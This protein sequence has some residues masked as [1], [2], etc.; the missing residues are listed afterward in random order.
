MVMLLL[1]AEPDSREYCHQG[2]KYVFCNEICFSS[3]SLYRLPLTMYHN[4][5]WHDI[6]S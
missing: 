2:N 1:K 6:L 4:A 3:S 5:I